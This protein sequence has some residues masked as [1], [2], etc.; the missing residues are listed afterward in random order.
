MS[1][2]SYNAMARRFLRCTAFPVAA[3]VVSRA[4][5]R[6]RARATPRTRLPRR[7]AAGRTAPTMLDDPRILNASEP[8]HE[9]SY[10]ISTRQFGVRVLLVSLSMLFAATLVAYV[11]TRI[12]NPVW[13]ARSLPRLP[14]GLFISSLL[15]LVTSVVLQS[16]VAAIRANRTRTLTLLLDCAGVLG[17][18][19][20]IVQALNWIALSR[21]AAGAGGNALYA[22]TFYLL[23]GLHAAHVIG[24]LVPLSIVGTRSRQNEYSSSR[25]EG[26]TLCV[27]YWHF[28]TIV[29][30]LLL[31]ALYL[32]SA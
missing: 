11:V 23:T 21:S 10:G 8:R 3:R 16:A 7:G 12:D 9:P 2:A 6:L 29:W 30:F 18:G 5:I 19:F 13:R 26:V 15:I 24:G 4:M 27:Q 20:L 32:G 14:P 1:G 25:T 28:L 31:F 22:F 17:V